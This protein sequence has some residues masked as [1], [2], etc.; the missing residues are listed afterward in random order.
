MSSMRISIVPSEGDLF[1]SF[2]GSR[3]NS[4]S[5]IATVVGDRNIFVRLVYRGVPF[6]LTACAYVVDIHAH[7]LKNFDIKANFCRAVPIA[8][9]LKWVS[10]DGCW[11]A[12]ETSACLIVDDPPLKTQYGFLHFGQT[13][14]SMDEHNFVMTIGFIPWNWRRTDPRAVQLFQARPDRLSLSIHGC[15]HTDGEFAIRSIT[16]LNAKTQ[17][18]SQ[19]MESL[20]QG[21]C[22]TYDRIMI[23]PHGEFSPEAA[24]VLKM[25]GFIA[26]VNTEVAPSRNA[27]NETEVAD[28]WNVA[29][30]RYEA[31]P[32]FTRRQPQQGIENFAF[33]GLLGKPCLIGAH[34][35]DF[36]DGARELLD[37]VD[38]LN[39][40]Q[41][42]LRWR[43]LGDVIRH[44]T[45]IRHQ[46]DSAS[47][48]QLYGNHAIVKNTGHKETRFSFVKKELDA[49]SIRGVITNGELTLWTCQGG[50]IRFEKI[51][52]PGQIV[53]IQIIYVENSN[54]GP[55]PSSIRYEMKIRLR[56]YLSELR[57]NYVSQHSVLHGGVT[58][59]TRYWKN[60]LAD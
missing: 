10:A 53:E 35:D 48:V 52:S 57:D 36:K 37:F 28:V 9:Y 19:R 4:Q 27:I 30:D 54:D 3:E 13:L 55:Y 41:W 26:A 6:Y 16:A 34:H 51:V 21:T 12:S 15:D 23:F 17:M 5:A 42:N 40:L 46:S 33:D 1:F 31:F 29:I 58:R 22:L 14:E 18:A 7:V 59:L 45:R 39:S 56:R 44:T 38:R 60:V 11:P 25:N 8:M 50:Y 2:L 24:Q 47:V 43:T 20:L 49:N 32:I